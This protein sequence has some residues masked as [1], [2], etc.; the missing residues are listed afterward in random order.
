MTDSASFEW[1]CNELER[2]TSLARLEARGTV[3][4][5][6]RAGGLESRSVTAEQLQVVLQRLL[7]EELAA[8]GV[9][10]GAQIAERVAGQLAK[11]ELD[12]AAHLLQYAVQWVGSQS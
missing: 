2:L 11:L 7:P 12:D 3:R 8:R 6:L 10:E 4:L 9:D 5:I 1:A